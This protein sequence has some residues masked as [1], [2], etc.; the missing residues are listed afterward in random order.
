MRSPTSSTVA[1]AILLGLASIV[2]AHGH[3]EDSNMNM[4]T[5]A[6]PRPIISSATSSATTTSVPVRDTYWT[7]S[8]HKGLLT[9]HIVLMTLAWIFVLPIGTQ[10][11]NLNL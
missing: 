11:S 4:G 6:V 5:A 2:V 1:G 10:F 3:D 7:Y 9:A 8:E